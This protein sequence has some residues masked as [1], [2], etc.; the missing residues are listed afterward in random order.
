MQ[1]QASKMVIGK[2]EVVKSNC[3]LFWWLCMSA[4]LLQYLEVVIDK[5][6]SEEVQRD[7]ERA[8]E[9]IRS[10]QDAN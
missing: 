10:V 8:I 1:F 6:E 2:S 9:V 5:N 3:L 4:I 7:I